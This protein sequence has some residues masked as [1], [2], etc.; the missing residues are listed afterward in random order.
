MNSLQNGNL[1][2]VRHDVCFGTTASVLAE[3]PSEAGPQALLLLKVKQYK[4]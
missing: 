4:L 3:T 2:G 1:R